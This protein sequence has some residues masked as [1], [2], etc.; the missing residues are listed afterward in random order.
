[1]KK[2][3]AIG[4]AT[5]LPTGLA[6][7]DPGQSDPQFLGTVS[8]VVLDDSMPL[9]KDLPCASEAIARAG[10]PEC[11]AVHRAVLNGRIQKTSAL[12]ERGRWL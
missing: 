8:V 12:R 3:L 11:M 2:L 5:C 1:M 10:R 4:L 9:A 7:E 6:A